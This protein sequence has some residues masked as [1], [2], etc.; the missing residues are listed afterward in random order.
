[1]IEQDV[2]GQVSGETRHVDT[3]QTIGSRPTQFSKRAELTTEDLIMAVEVYKQNIPPKQQILSQFSIKPIYTSLGPAYPS[4]DG[5]AAWIVNS[6]GVYLVTN[7]D[8]RPKTMKEIVRRRTEQTD[9][10]DKT[11]KLIEQINEPQQRPDSSNYTEYFDVTEFDDSGTDVFDD[12]ESDMIIDKPTIT[13]SD[14]IEAFYNY[15][16]TLDDFMKELMQFVRNNNIT[17]SYDSI[18][19]AFNQLQ[20]VVQPS[21]TGVNVGSQKQ[22]MDYVCYIDVDWK[23]ALMWMLLLN[24]N[25]DIDIMRLLLQFSIKPIEEAINWVFEVLRSISILGIRPFG[26]LPIIQWYEDIIYWF[27]LNE[28]QL[29]CTFM[30]FRANMRIGTDIGG[31]EFLVQVVKNGKLRFTNVGWMNRD[32]RRVLAMLQMGYNWQCSQIGT[33]FTVAQVRQIVGNILDTTFDMYNVPNK[34]LND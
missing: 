19:D 13:T 22:L 24:F 34:P 9:W 8:L 21:T 23:T 26:W 17:D 14:V 2:P 12:G 29:M 20:I 11:Q 33:V 31:K 4:R 3:N 6:S 16:G 27:A 32:Q 7:L 25:Q 5:T 30:R 18:Q 15:S 1:M 10:S 28:Y